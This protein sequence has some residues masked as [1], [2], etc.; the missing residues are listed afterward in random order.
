MSPS[1]TPCP[2]PVPVVRMRVTEP[3]F[4]MVTAPL[5]VLPFKVRPEPVA[6]QTTYGLDAERTQ[7][8]VPVN[9]EFPETPEAT[10]EP[11]VSVT[12]PTFRNTTVIV[13]WL[14]PVVKIASSIDTLD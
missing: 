12:E 1:V 6:A 4:E 10:S 11:T 2:V 8:S 3:P 7:V 13:A 9:A 5:M 14:L